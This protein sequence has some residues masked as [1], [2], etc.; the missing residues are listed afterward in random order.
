[1]ELVR[2]LLGLDEFWRQRHGQQFAD[3][4]D[5]GLA[6][7]AREQPVVPDAVE[8]AWQNMQQEPAHELGNSDKRRHG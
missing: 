6:C 3:A 2:R 1:L 5:V 7:R 4:G 8:A